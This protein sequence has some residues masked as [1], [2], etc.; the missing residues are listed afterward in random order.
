[1]QYNE[2]Y[3]C[4][5]CVADMVVVIATVNVSGAGAGGDGAGGVGVG[6]SLQIAVARCEVHSD[7]RCFATHARHSAVG[8]IGSPHWTCKE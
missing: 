2:K 7:G 4:S 3:I 5:P 6:G 8:G 1:M